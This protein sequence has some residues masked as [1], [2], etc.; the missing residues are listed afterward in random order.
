M[1]KKDHLSIFRYI[2]SLFFLMMTVSLISS[3]GSSDLL[4][5]ID[6]ISALQP[7]TVASRAAGQ[8]EGKGSEEEQK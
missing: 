8:A 4:Q 3:C 1:Q 6:S 5:K 2:V 7:E